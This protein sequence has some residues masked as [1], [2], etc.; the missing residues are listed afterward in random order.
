MIEQI[1]TKTAHLER[2]SDTDVVP[3][4]W[5]A[6]EISRIVSQLP[7]AEQDSAVLTGWRGARIEYQHRRSD[8]EVAHDR[9]AILMQALQ[10]NAASG[11]TREQIEEL[12]T[13][14]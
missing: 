8:L 14:V 13:R 10:V 3:A 12:L 7:L 2:T 9:L 4:R 5:A 6:A 11:M 1:V